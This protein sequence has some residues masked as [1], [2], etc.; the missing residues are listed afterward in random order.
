MHLKLVCVQKVSIESVILIIE[1]NNLQKLWSKYVGASGVGR[2]T[3]ICNNRGGGCLCVYI[4][5]PK[6]WTNPLDI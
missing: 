2:S 6:Q 3:R 4:Y 1:V 5:H